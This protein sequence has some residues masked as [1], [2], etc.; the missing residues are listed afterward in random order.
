MTKSHILQE[1]K[2]TA[3]ENGGAPLG[4]ALFEA[5][6]GIRNPDWFGVHWA[7]WGDALREAGFR[8]NQLNSA[9]DK[10]HLL[11]KYAELALELGRLPVL[12]DLRLKRR[13]DPEF[14]SGNTFSRLG[15]KAD[16]L[17]QLVEFCCTVKEFAA[18]IVL[19]EGQL[20]RSERDLAQAVRGKAQEW[21]MV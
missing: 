18:V 7:R 19:C 1:I 10:Q 12:G 5:K 13:R 6:T 17:G 9:Y 21:G 16:L 3:E 4:S 11:R 14:P 15:K 2:R 20:Q 8:P